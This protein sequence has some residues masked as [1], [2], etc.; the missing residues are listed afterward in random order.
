[1]RPVTNLRE[2]AALVRVERLQPDAVSAEDLAELEAAR[3]TRRSECV[4]GMRPC[5]FVS[6]R[7][8]LALDVTE[9]GSMRLTAELLEDMADTCALDVADRGPNGYSVIARALGVSLERARQI[10]EAALVKVRAST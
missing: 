8:H 3:P 9:A 6:C 10:C 5:P 7:H 1:M 4:G 2:L